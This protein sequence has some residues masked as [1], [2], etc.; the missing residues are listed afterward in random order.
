MIE[1]ATSHITEQDFKVIASIYFVAVVLCVCVCVRGC[2]VGKRE[3]SDILT[4]SPGLY[5]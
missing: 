4:Y 1:D 2:W 3:K 5:L